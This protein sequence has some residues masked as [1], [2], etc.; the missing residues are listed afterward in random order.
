MQARGTKPG[1]RKRSSRSSRF[2]WEMQFIVTALF[3]LSPH[4]ASSSH[5]K[6]ERGRVRE[7]TEK[8]EILCNC[9]AYFFVGNMIRA[10]FNLTFPYVQISYLMFYITDKGS[11]ILSID[12]NYCSFS[13]RKIKL[14][15]FCYLRIANYNAASL[16]NDS[17]VMKLIECLISLTKVYLRVRIVREVYKTI[18]SAS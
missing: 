6:D 8:R 17:E 2:P 4:M 3:L 16:L 13:W 18:C 12:I 1:N 14:Y 15:H 7:G 9:D 11:Y 10:F 5:R